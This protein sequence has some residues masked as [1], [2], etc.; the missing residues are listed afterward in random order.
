VSPVSEVSAVAVI[1]TDFAMQNV[2]LQM[3]LRL[4]SV[5]GL[6]VTTLRSW[7]KRCHGCFRCVGGSSSHSFVSFRQYLAFSSHNPFDVCA[8][9]YYCTLFIRM[10]H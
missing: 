3:G 6:A 9:V 2:L 8:V 10:Q 4:L 1:T 5:N 7:I